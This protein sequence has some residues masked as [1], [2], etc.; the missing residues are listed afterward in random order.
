MVLYKFAITDQN[1]PPPGK[2]FVRLDANETDPD[3][4]FGGVA[5]Q[6][7]IEIDDSID[8]GDPTAVRIE[9]LKVIEAWCKE[10]NLSFDPKKCIMTGI[11]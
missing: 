8:F 9:A 1:G 11:L 7:H 2:L 4:G 5:V 10:H 3:G 6:A